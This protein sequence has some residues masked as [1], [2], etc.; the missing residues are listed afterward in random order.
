[1]IKRIFDFSFSIFLI[2]ILSWLICILFIIASVNFKSFGIFSQERIGQFGKI[3]MIYKIKSMNNKKD[4]NFFGLFIRK[5]K[6]DELPQLFNIV[7]GD[8]SFVGPR[9]DISGY[10]DKLEGDDRK[11]LELKPGLTCEASLKYKDEEDTLK[12]EKNPLLFNDTIIFPDKLKMN[13]EYYKNHN[14]FVDLHI[15][16]KTIKK[17]TK[18][19]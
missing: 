3:F 6:L 13:L 19:I 16:F 15:I 9:P 12:L 5:Y 11:I 18:S 7:K 8:M 17:I 2:F 10:Y 1:M 4:K 14:I